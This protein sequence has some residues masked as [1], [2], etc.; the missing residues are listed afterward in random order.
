MSDAG[1][2][3]PTIAENVRADSTAGS[4]TSS[5]GGPPRPR[6][7]QIAIARNTTS[8]YER[9]ERARTSHA[10]EPC[11]ERKTKCDGERP[12]CRRC[13]HTGTPCHYG[14]GKGW[15]KR[16]TAEDLTVTSRK[17]A[18]YEELL[19]EIYPLVANDV[20]SIIDNVRQQDFSVHSPNE[21]SDGSIAVPPN[22]FENDLSR[23]SPSLNRLPPPVSSSLGHTQ[24]APA[25]TGVSRPLSIALST[26]LS[27]SPVQSPPTSTRSPIDD[28]NSAL[29]LPSITRQGFLV[30]G[31]ARPRGKL[32]FPTGSDSA[33]GLDSFP[34]DLSKR[35][36]TASGMT[37]FSSPFNR[38]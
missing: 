37:H 16:K 13:L 4:P 8:G 25:F 12:S 7:K 9:P 5:T 24:S 18:R 30:D 32:P 17:L 2:S 20:R 36:S 26:E 6:P 29:R 27:V 11:R 31:V 33:R 15:K 14:Y 1:P 19:V 22:N 28:N 21:P 3:T 34:A 10:C 23:I 38:H 35:D